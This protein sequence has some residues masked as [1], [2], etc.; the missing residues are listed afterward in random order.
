MPSHTTK[1]AHRTRLT[2]STDKE[3]VSLTVCDRE[4]FAHGA[5]LEIVCES[6]SLHKWNFNHR[7]HAGMVLIIGMII[8]QNRSQ[9]TPLIK[10]ARTWKTAKNNSNVLSRNNPAITVIRFNPNPSR[11]TMHVINRASAIYIRVDLYGKRGGLRVFWSLT[12]I[13]E[14]SEVEVR[15]VQGSLVADDDVR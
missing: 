5:R 10:S 8:Y 3:T 7:I 1:S 2:V 6:K 13:A 11:S 9:K 4:S 14:S 12:D 15:P